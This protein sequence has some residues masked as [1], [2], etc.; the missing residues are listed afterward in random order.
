MI[1]NYGG[2]YNEYTMALIRKNQIIENV[3]DNS[4][5]TVLEYNAYLDEYYLNGQPLDNIW[6]NTPI[7]GEAYWMLCVLRM[8]F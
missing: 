2:N 6:T 1:F 3:Y 8:T 7:S 5:L 4:G